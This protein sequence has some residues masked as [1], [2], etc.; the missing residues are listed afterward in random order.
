MNAKTI[1]W[2][3]FLLLIVTHLDF[4]RPQRAELYFGWMPEDLVYRLLWMA[5][6]WA[7]LIFFTRKVWTEED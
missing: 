1:A 5:G 7:Y 3:G 6:A 2:I 4:W